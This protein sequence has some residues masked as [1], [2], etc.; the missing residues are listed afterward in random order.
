[1]GRGFPMNSNLPGEVVHIR[2]LINQI[3]DETQCSPDTVKT[4]LETA[5]VIVEDVLCEEKIVFLGENHGYFTWELKLDESN[6]ILYRKISFIQ[7]R[8]LEQRINDGHT[9]FH[10]T[11][12]DSA[13]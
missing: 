8:Q 7:S 13:F 1:M 5:A 4:I 10:D 2:N 6:N 11:L 3:A 12:S 9:P